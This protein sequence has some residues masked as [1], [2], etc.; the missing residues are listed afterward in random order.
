MSESTNVY[1]PEDIEKN[2]IIAALAYLVFFIPLI[3]APESK[4]GRYHA[5]QGLVLNI[6][7]I[8]IS[9]VGSIFLYSIPFFGWAVSLA[10]NLGMLFLAF[11]G[12]MNA[13]NGKAVPLPVI[14]SI[15]ILK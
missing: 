11:S 7:E 15:T 9:V 4:F 13:Y 14:G 6:A 10:L 12:F 5:N 8:L 1:T 3:A 2:K